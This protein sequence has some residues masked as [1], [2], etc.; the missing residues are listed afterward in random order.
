MTIKVLL[1]HEAVKKKLIWPWIEFTLSA[2]TPP[3]PGERYR[4]SCQTECMPENIAMQLYLVSSEFEFHCRAQ[5]GSF[6]VCQLSLTVC[7]PLLYAG[8]FKS[9]SLLRPPSLPPLWF[10]PTRR[11]EWASCRLPAW[12]LW[13]TE[14]IRRSERRIPLV[15][16]PSLSRQGL[17]HRSCSSHPRITLCHIQMELS[18]NQKCF[19][20]K[21]VPALGGL[22]A[23][24]RE[25]LRKHF[26]QPLRSVWLP[27]SFQLSPGGPKRLVSLEVIVTSREGRMADRKEGKKCCLVCV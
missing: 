17:I 23:A 6:G 11:P 8:Y 19:F 18:G 14:L 20:P 24:P 1:L 15:F 26:A 13:D 22:S 16:G 4:V 21:S 9:L 10:P 5:T 7:F 2:W 27:H 25:L 12:S 3:S